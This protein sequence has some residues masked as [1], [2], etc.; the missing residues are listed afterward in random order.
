M[1]SAPIKLELFNFRIGEPIR[2]EFAP[3]VQSALV[4]EG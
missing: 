1:C 4:A 3:S 2:L